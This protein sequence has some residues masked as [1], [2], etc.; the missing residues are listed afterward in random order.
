METGYG[1][2][3]LGCPWGVS[4]FSPASCVGL[5]VSVSFSKP[6]FP[7]VR[8]KRIGPISLVSSHC[9][10]FIFNDAFLTKYIHAHERKSEACG[11]RRHTNKKCLSSATQKIALHVFNA[12]TR[13]RSGESNLCNVFC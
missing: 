7:Y 5:D 13:Y 2:E 6:Q 9:H 1:A 8:S 12:Y 4:A 10:H 3:K 11:K